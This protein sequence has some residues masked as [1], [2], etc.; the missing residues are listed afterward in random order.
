MSSQLQLDGRYYKL[1]AN[2]YEVGG[3]STPDLC[4]A[5]PTEIPE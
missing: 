1:V 5:S 4:V 3:E 2:A